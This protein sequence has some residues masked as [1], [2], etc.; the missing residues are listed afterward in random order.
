MPLPILLH[1]QEQILKMLVYHLL[2]L[3]LR[4][5]PTTK[6]NTLFILPKS[7]KH[8]KVVTLNKMKPQER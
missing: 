4:I 8:H 6:K 3:Y 5:L 1:V 2:K 7:L